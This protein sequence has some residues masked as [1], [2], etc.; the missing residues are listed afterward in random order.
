M[1][2][3]V[4]FPLAILII[5][6]PP[7]SI[8]V[9]VHPQKIEVRFED[10]G[11]L[12]RAVY[13]AISQAIN[14]KS[15]VDPDVD[16]ELQNVAI[17]PDRFCYHDNLSNGNFVRVMNDDPFRPL[18]RQVRDTQRYPSYSAQRDDRAISNMFNSIANENYFN[19]ILNTNKKFSVNDMSTENLQKNLNSEMELSSL[20]EELPLSS[21]N[22]SNHK[23]KPI[24]QVDLCYIIAQSEDEL[25]IID[26][27]AAHERILFD[28]LSGYTD[29]IPAQQLLVHQIL[30]F[31][32]YEAKL[33]EDYQEL[34]H[35]LG[36][37]MELSGENEYRLMEIP[38]DV[39]NAD[40][41]GILREILSSLP[42]IDDKNSLDD[43]QHQIITKN[44]R[45]ACLATTACRAAIKAGQELNLRQMQMLIDQLSQTSHPFTCPHGRPTILKFSSHDLAKM[46]K[47][48]GF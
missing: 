21:D 31:D 29:G 14:E 28:R 26:Q 35:K 10:E 8:D 36:F 33:I 9:N 46:F 38:V 47:R 42:P 37:T 22:V 32:D 43:E 2:P 6:V 1:I 27:H 30:N 5:D 45:Q 41:E 34:F 12:Y 15:F 13:G 40:S 19:D 11:K 24:S 17:T 48:T 18:K 25:Y 44:I 16:D 7:L 3:K 39:S 4:G 20:N 23:I